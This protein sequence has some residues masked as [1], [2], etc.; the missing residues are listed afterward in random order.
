MQD[1]S[2]RSRFTSRLGA[3]LAIAAVIGA[4]WYG[5]ASLSYNWQWYRIPRLLLPGWRG[6]AWT[7][8]PLAE[9]LRLTLVLAACSAPL[10]IAIGLAVA[11]LEKSR[12]VSLRMFGRSYIE[13]V[14][15]TPLLVQLYLLYFMLA[16]LLGIDR[17][18][19][20][21]LALALFEGAF[22][23]EI[24]R[25]GIDA[26][27]RGQRDA[28]G[29][30]GLRPLAAFRLVYLPQSLPL[31]LPPLA[32]LFVSLIKHSSIVS[33][34]ALPELTDIARNLIA[35]TYLTFEIWLVVALVYVVL[36]FA[37]SLLIRL[38]EARLLARVNGGRP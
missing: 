34:V 12:L 18:A 37:L 20:G 17:T 36:C 29:A 26:V 38:W 7:W 23:A 1:S 27:P 33:V 13:L 24:F 28:A 10:A 6:D 16:N 30:L 31:I 25:A 19:A 4:I 15:N 32:N 21:V 5:A 22:A 14:R 11:L 3:F 9:G 8:G 2:F 35:D